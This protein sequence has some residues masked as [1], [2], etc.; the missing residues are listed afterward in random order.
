LNKEA[1]VAG[2]KLVLGGVDPS[3]AVSDWQYHTL[4]SDTY[5]KI[6]IEDFLVNGK[7]IGYKGEMS[8]IVDSGTSTLA[9]DRHIIDIISHLVG[10]V[11]EMCTGMDKMP[12]VTVV[13]KGE[14]GLPS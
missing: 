4:T 9:G 12:T 14:K 7:S 5:W 3:L 6:G 10:P 1:G 11:N 8:G 13:I 2:S